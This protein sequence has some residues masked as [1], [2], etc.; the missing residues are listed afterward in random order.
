VTTLSTFACRFATLR[1]MA[2][3]TPDTHT[4]EPLRRETLTIEQASVAVRV[5]RRTIYNWM[6]SGKI[7]WTSTAGGAKRIYADTLWKNRTT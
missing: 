3:D 5:S 7:E 2:Q 1:D 4:T 6:E